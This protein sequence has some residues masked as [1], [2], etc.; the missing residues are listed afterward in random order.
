MGRILNG[1]AIQVISTKSFI[2]I[3]KM[4]IEMVLGI[5]GIQPG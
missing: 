5:I 2:K 4:V 3:L 1:L